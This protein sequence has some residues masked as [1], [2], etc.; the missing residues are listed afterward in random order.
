MKNMIYCTTELEDLAKTRSSI[1]VKASNVIT[2]TIKSMNENGSQINARD[3]SNALKSFSDS[4]KSEIL[5]MVVANLCK[6]KIITNKSNSNGKR[7]DLF[8]GVKW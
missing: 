4:E 8:S 1:M 5:M 2:E 3:L 7:G 6:C